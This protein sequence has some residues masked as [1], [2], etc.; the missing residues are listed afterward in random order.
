MSSLKDPNNFLNRELS[1]LHFIER[2]L[3]QAQDPEI[4]LLER[5]NYL[6]IS[7]ANLDE[8]FEIRV[9]DIK[10]RSL[11][12]NFSS[13]PDK[14]N[15]EDLL[16]IISTQVHQII[17]E[18]YAL[19]NIELLP[20]IAKHGVILVNK[21]NWTI[22]QKNWIK[23]YFYNDILPIL[24]PV[25]LDRT[26]PFPRLVNKSLNF[27]V[28]LDGKDA[29][30]RDSGLAI[31]HTPRALSRLIRLPQ[32]L[33]NNGKLHFIYL[34]DIIKTYAIELFPGMKIS[35]CYQLRLTRDSDLFLDEAGAE[36]L[37]EAL[38]SE[39]FSRRYGNA[40]RLELD[41]DCPDEIADFLLKKHDLH[42]RDLY[43]I[44]GPVNLT[45]YNCLI[46]IDNPTLKFPEYNPVIS[47][48]L[49]THTDFFEAIRQKDILL[50][51]PFEAFLS[52]I[53]LINQAARD[54][55]VRAIKATLYRSGTD[56]KMVYALEEAARAGKE[57]TVVVELRARFD[58]A[59]NIEL[60]SRLHE[61]GALVT[62]GV[63]NY[64]THAKMLMF[65]RQEDNKLV[66]Y[67]HLSTGN[68]H[69]TNAKHYTDIGLLT[70]DEAITQDVQNVFQQLTGMGDILPLKK[71]FA[72]PF[73]LYDNIV[74][75]IKHEIKQAK[76]GKPA[77][78]I[79]RLNALTEHKI[80]CLLYEASMAGVEIDLLVRGACCLRPGLDTI[81]KHIR[82][83]AIVDRF[84]EHAR[85]YYFYHNGTEKVY[86]SSADWMDRNLF[87]RVEVCFP[88]EQPSLKKRLIDETLTAYLEDHS[89]RWLLHADGSYH[90]VK[91]QSKHTLSA[92]SYLMKQYTA[93]N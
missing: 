43:R 45:R 22:K 57:V 24:S 60:A 90:R 2:V 38:K 7:S 33:H 31:V 10:K 13:G 54:P 28:S 39:L 40:V 48:R 41:K 26:H 77:R 19:L 63:M 76:A 15:S 17:E 23:Q 52:I 71:L 88:I 32:T 47:K 3:M 81:S 68:Y 6:M 16:N 84:L 72:A 49:Q 61:A 80:I 21:D 65:V 74:H 36:S 91:K 42:T 14:T 59:E 4:P 75:L 56:S 73:T 64:K 34:S 58:E 46:D 55:N 86:C 53:D 27:I 37:P 5:L 50:F 70:Y 93:N 89:Q 87:H 18:Q 12:G 1:T 25:G 20:A 11:A 62:Y 51:H 8:F 67:A 83:H 29:F 82:V 30:G 44:N 78:I 92:Q 66:R 69:S 9:A 79:A 85:V 35:G